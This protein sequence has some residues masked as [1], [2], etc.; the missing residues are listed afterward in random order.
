M[1]KSA[2]LLLAVALLVG[3]FL[4]GGL[5]APVP[6]STTEK[7]ALTHL[8]LYADESGL[9]RVSFG[10]LIR[11]GMPAADVRPEHI[12]VLCRGIE[13]PRKVVTKVPNVID[14]DGY[15]ELYA[16]VTPDQFTSV[17]AYQL[18]WDR[19]T[20]GK[21]L[22]RLDGSPKSN[23][24]IVTSFQDVVH[25]EE[26]HQIWPQTPG[27]PD[28]DY[29]FWS[30]HLAP[31]TRTY[32]LTIADPV[33]TQSNALARVGFQGQ[34]T[35][36]PTPN[37][38][39]L[40]AL[41]GVSIGDERWHGTSAHVQQ[42]LVPDGVLV[43]GKNKLTVE[44][45]NDTGAR[46]DVVFDNWIELSYRRHLRA[47]NGQ[48]RFTT[49]DRG[50]QRLEV[51]GFSEPAIIVYD[52]TKPL[53]PQQVIGGITAQ[54]PEGYRIS[55]D[56]ELSNN[57]T[58]LAVANSKVKRVSRVLAPRGPQLRR[59]DNR[60]DY[61]LI[62]PQALF[63]AVRPLLAHRQAQGLHTRLV[64]L[65]TVY[66][67]FNYG[68]LNPK[69]IRRFL[70]YAYQHW[71]KPAP[72][73]VLLVGDASYDY[74][75]YLPTN[76]RNKVPTQLSFL[77]K[78][79]L[80]PDDHWYVCLD[81][82]DDLIADMAIGRLPGQD[83]ATVSMVVRKILQYEQ[84]NSRPPA[85]T[86]FVAD[87]TRPSERLSEFLIAKLPEGFEARKI[88]R[89]AY[90]NA[91]Q[92]APDIVAAINQGMLVTTYAGHGYARGWSKQYMFTPE[93]L[94][95][96]TND[97][98][99]TFVIM[100]T[101]LSGY[102]ASPRAYSLAEEFLTAPNSGAVACLAPSG[103]GYPTDHLRLAQALFAGLFDDP[104]LDLGSAV[105]RAKERALKQGVPADLVRMFTLFGDPA[106]RLGRPL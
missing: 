31:A 14:R 99:L 95:A 4:A 100:L 60:G 24:R 34:T 96:L 102:F 106:M 36:P 18:T 81:G 49:Q 54:T 92:V 55:F 71:A 97:R 23:A 16:Q 52:T 50:R 73:Y 84:A 20:T 8:W 2:E 94:K 87:E 86:L 37:H 77:K 11:A 65:E 44:S 19:P 51:R 12:Q 72:K 62:T 35:A 10:E 48:L 103:L 1:S 80:S 46:V 33:P 26:N 45:V 90:S 22:E 53:A 59:R 9:Y 82:E 76:K 40:V 42:A 27:A 67:Q 6:D 104:P 64:S 101:C 63:P 61:L 89:S 47:R 32:Q 43:A 30:K 98:K 105:K 39:T 17:N 57:R 85:Q 69:A 66:Q 56:V 68:V 83:A 74:R 78:T 25:V 79:G 41:N 21:Q 88:Y 91:K 70:R 38:H 75:G 58:F 15:V 3:S 13:V 7:A 93:H 29:W 5:F 28:R